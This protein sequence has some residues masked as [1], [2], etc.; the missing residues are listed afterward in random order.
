MAAGV[1]AD[2]LE[3]TKTLPKLSE[4]PEVSRETINKS[5][6][7][8]VSLEVL[9]IIEQYFIATTAEISRHKEKEIEKEK[10]RTEQ[11]NNEEDK[12]DG[13]TE[14]TP[15]KKKKSKKPKKKVKEEDLWTRF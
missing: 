14:G 10:L 5:N 9:N 11:Q 12:K 13:E 7:I 2:F 8:K 6:E 3:F 1:L 4:F 15:D